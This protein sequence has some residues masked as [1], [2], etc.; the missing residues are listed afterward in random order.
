[1][2]RHRDTVDPHSAPGRWLHG[3]HSDSMGFSGQHLVQ[4]VAGD[5]QRIDHYLLGVVEKAVDVHE[6]GCAGDQSGPHPARVI[7]GGEHD[8][9]LVGEKC[10]SGIRNLVAHHPPDTLGHR[11]LPEALL[12]R[13]LAGVI[14][15]HGAAQKNPQVGTAPSGAGSVS[16]PWGA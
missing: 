1:V 12:H 5:G 7:R 10:R 3:D 16:A 6:S 2:A 13:Q 9:R 15:A 4:R 8:H 14:N 11:A